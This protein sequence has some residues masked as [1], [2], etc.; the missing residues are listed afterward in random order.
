MSDNTIYIA[1]GASVGT[2]LLLIIVVVG[3]IFFI[4]YRRRN[5]QYKKMPESLHEELISHECGIF[6]RFIF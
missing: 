1:I 6:T 5:S 3:I 2:L 4:T